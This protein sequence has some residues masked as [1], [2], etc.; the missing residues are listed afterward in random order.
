MYKKILSAF[1][2][3][4]ANLTRIMVY[5]NLEKTLINEKVII[6]NKFISI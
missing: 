5:Y 2:Y 1:L 4:Y 6:K 3:Y